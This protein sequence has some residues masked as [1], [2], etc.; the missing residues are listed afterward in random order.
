MITLAK[1]TAGKFVLSI[2]LICMILSAY[3]Y[4]NFFIV[5]AEGMLFLYFAKTIDC[6]LYGG[7][8]V[9]SVFP[10]A[11]TFIIALFLIFDYFGIFDKYKYA[12][13]KLYALFENSNESHLKQILFPD[14]THLS[15]RYKNRVAPK[16]FNKN[17]RYTK[18]YNSKLYNHHKKEALE[19]KNKISESANTVVTKLNLNMNMNMNN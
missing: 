10:I 1:S 12:I 8:Y 5:L 6:G 13:Q 11:I 19:F 2:G 7:C 14:E 17:Y 4:Y 9:T 3:K 18:E 16:L 15:D